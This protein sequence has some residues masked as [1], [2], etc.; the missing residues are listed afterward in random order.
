MNDI[1]LLYL[2][3]NLRSAVPGY[4]MEVPTVDGM[5]YTLLR[6]PPWPR[7]S[8]SESMRPK[9]KQLTPPQR[10]ATVM[11]LELVAQYVESEEV[12]HEATVALILGIVAGSSFLGRLAAEGLTTKGTPAATAEVGLN[13]FRK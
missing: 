3:N 4:D 7:L 6:D 2:V 9:V 5:D 11:F 10:R 1:I 13:W 12:R 8:L